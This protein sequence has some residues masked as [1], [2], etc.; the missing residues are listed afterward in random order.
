MLKR[1]LALTLSLLLLCAA[2]LGETTATGR[3]STPRGTQAG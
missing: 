1:A 3:C 2:A